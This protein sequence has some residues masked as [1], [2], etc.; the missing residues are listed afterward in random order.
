[1]DVVTD[2]LYLNETWLE[3]KLAKFRDVL[4]CGQKV[5]TV[6][7]DDDREKMGGLSA[8][9]AFISAKLSGGQTLPLIVKT[10]SASPMRVRTGTAREALFYKEFSAQLAVG[11]DGNDGANADAGIVPR[12]Y[13]AD[14]NMETGEMVVIMDCCKNAIPLGVFFGP[15]NPNNWSIADRIESMNEGNPGPKEASSTAFSLY[16]K[17]HGTYWEDESLKDKTFLRCS[18]WIQGKGKEEWQGAQDLG[19]GWWNDALKAIEDGTGHIQWDTHLVECLKVSFN[20]IDWNNFQSELSKRPFSLVQGDCHPHNLLW[21]EQRTPSAHCKLIDFEM[22]GLGSPAQDIGQF[23]ISHM[24]PGIRREYEKE[25]VTGY[26]QELVK[27]LKDTGK[28]GVQY[29][30]DDCWAEYVAGG[31][32]RWAWFMAYFSLPSNAANLSQFFHDQVAAFC[33]DHIPT[34]DDAPM[35]RV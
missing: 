27:V 24:P 21:V 15:T 2:K 10:S 33:K 18:N 31:F 30:F 1:M 22:V 26:H 19:R 3:S 17:L 28:D 34:A 12:A 4:P 20:K 8:D 23:L 5:V 11:S 32:G 13:H 6:A 35:P 25:L 16:A 9:I 29:S 14:A 7:P